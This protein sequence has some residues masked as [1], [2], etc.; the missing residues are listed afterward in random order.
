M[1]QIVT[2]RDLSYSPACDRG[3]PGRGRNSRGASLP[4]TGN[5]RLRL[6]LALVLSVVSAPVW[7]AETADP[8]PTT[9]PATEP[10]V[11]TAPDDADAGEIVV[12]AT[13]LRGQIDAPQPP[14]VTLNEADIQSYGVSSL[15]DLVA[16]LAPQTSSGRGRGGGFPAILVN[17][18]RIGSFREMRNFPPEAIRR[19]EVLPEE[20]AQRYGFPPDQRVINFILK[21]QFASRTAELNYRQ[22]TRGGNSSESAELS[23]LTISGPRRTNLTVTVDHA[24]PLTEGERNVT[25]QPGTVPTVTGDLQPADF[26]TLIGQSTNLGANLTWN[27]ALGKAPD[28]GTLGLNAAIARGRTLGFSGLSTV[29]LTAPGGATAVRSLGDPLARQ[30]DTLSLSGGL[31]LNKPLGDWQ[32]TVTSDGTHSEAVSHIDRRPS[33]AALVVAAANGSLALNAPLNLGSAGFDRAETRSDSIANVAT[34]IGRPVHLPAGDVAVTARAGFAYSAIDSRDTR[35]LSGPTDLHRS[36]VSAG[37]NIG[38][39]IASRRNL[40]LAGLGDLNLNFSAG[41]DRLSDFG[42]L[43]DWSA[44]L[45]WGVTR[46]LT[47]GA[48]YIANQ[49]APSLGNLGNPQVQTFNVPVFDFSRGETALV[50][51]TSGG[52]PAL[53]K[54]TDRDL[55][56]S[57]NWQLPIANNGSLLVEYFRNRSNNVTSSFPLLT[58]GIEA[59]FPGRVTRDAGGRLTAIDQRPVTLFSQNASR[60]RAGINL[61]GSLGK[62]APSEGGMFGMGGGGGARGGARGGR[63][64]GGA[65]GG[66]GGPGGGGGLPGGFG[67]G[68]GGQGRWNVSLSDTIQLTNKIVVGPGGPA[69]NLLGGDAL[70]GGG[71]ARHTVE[72]DAGGFYKGFGL[73]LSGSYASPTRI[74]ASGLPGST[75]LRFGSLLKLNTRLFVDLGQQRS[76]AKAHPFFRGARLSVFV[77]NVFDQ[78]QRVIDGNGAAPIS[79]Q[80]DLIDP[81]GRTIGIEFRKQF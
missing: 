11:A 78:R 19:V 8:A 29:L 63:G 4:T 36:D 57:A 52:N 7:G 80:P 53:R 68:R 76:L 51:L 28:A 38:V 70:T 32:L 71:V 61:M 20:T 23:T 75:D 16:A 59:A 17:G 5:Y 79:Y 65:R 56:L 18:Q 54:E 46:T 1:R 25:Q 40:A 37:L 55:K 27:T 50:T 39:P 44:G 58:P 43:F 31:S 26:R 62:A 33:S 15:A 3:E 64:G 34:F 45:T 22:P 42:T 81:Q 13:R 72:L 14:I 9:P 74:D 73:R 6:T 47:L 24:T 69:L 12:I 21:D 77:N 66:S 60:I 67:G 35:T 10:P 48:S 2:G 41:V 49:Q 30:S